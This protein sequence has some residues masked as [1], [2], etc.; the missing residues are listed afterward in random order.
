[1]CDRVHLLVDVQDPAVEADVKRPPRREWLIIVH[2]SVG[3]GDRFGGVAQQRIVDTK[4]LRECLVGFRRIDANRKM[5]DVEAP[6]LIA[7]L[8]E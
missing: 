8:T 7:T 3:A 6:D 4:R 5:S 2:N 1:M